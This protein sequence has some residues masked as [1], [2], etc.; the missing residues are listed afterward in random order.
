MNTDDELVIEILLQIKKCIISNNMQGICD[1]YN[2][3][4][5]EDLSIERSKE[6]RLS[7]IKN[8]LKSQSEATIDKSV[9]I[10]RS[11]EE[12]LSHID[13]EF[14]MPTDGVKAKS[15]KRPKKRT[16]R[17]EALKVEN[18]PNGDIRYYDKPPVP[19]SWD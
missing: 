11:P 6:D 1:L 12:D 19:P 8:K 10:D 14:R 3:L 7:D 17:L 4:S 16:N 9:E 5:G 15:N 13:D 2:G 18:N